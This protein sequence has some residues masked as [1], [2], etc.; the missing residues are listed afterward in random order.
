[1][2]RIYTIITI[3]KMR[4]EDRS[5]GS[6]DPEQVKRRHALPHRDREVSPTGREAFLV[7]SEPTPFSECL[8]ETV[9]GLANIFIAKPTFV[10]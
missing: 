8:A 2:S 1:M 7:M 10:L 4:A 6:P 9:F 5:S 3:S